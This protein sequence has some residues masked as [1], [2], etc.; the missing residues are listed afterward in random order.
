[1]IIKN[2][3]DHFHCYKCIYSTELGIEMIK[4]IKKC[5]EI[6]NPM[7]KRLTLENELETLRKRRIRYDNNAIEEKSKIIALQYQINTHKKIL[8]AIE[9]NY[10]LLLL[11]MTKR[12]QQI[13]GLDDIRNVS[14]EVIEKSIR[15]AD[16]D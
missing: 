13:E 14:D 8:S 16:N 12:E 10:E 9:A 5:H 15:K 11:N 2:P 4:H 3:K 7:T 1:M 6:E